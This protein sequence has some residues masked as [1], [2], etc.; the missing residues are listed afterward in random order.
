LFFKKLFR[1]LGKIVKWINIALMIT[2]AVLSIAGALGAVKALVWL[3]RLGKLGK[4]IFNLKKVG[5]RWKGILHKAA[6]FLYA[7]GSVSA[8]IGGK[9]TKETQKKRQAETVNVGLIDA[10]EI[11]GKLPTAEQ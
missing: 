10:V 2:V 4:V 5:W 1:G 3:N 6:V 7:V 8:A 9:N 11:I